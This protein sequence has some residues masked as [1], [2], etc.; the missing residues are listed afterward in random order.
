M[1][2]VVF[3]YTTERT[4]HLQRMR[5]VWLMPLLVLGVI[6]WSLF[7]DKPIDDLAVPAFG[8]IGFA[9]ALSGMAW[10]MDRIA[11]GSSLV[12]T[13]NGILSSTARRAGGMVERSV[14]L[15][16]TSM[17]VV[18]TDEEGQ[19][20]FVEAERPGGKKTRLGVHGVMPEAEV[21][22]LLDAIERAA[23]GVHTVSNMV[24][25]LRTRDMRLLGR[26]RWRDRSLFRLMLRIDALGD[27]LGAGTNVVKRVVRDPIKNKV[28]V[29]LRPGSHRTRQI[30]GQ[31]EDRRL[32]LVEEQ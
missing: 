29:V 3:S 32:H 27:D 9:V 14:S 7:T 18:Q 11:K 28:T 24:T 10:A 13:S 12:L 19:S 16:D 23:P 22:V 15:T 25:K 17:V 26:L 1:D 2:D 30:I 5:W 8:A 20:T 6:V 21:Y 31:L 4:E